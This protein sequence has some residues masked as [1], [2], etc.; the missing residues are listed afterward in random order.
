MPHEGT[1]REVVDLVLAFARR[2]GQVPI[3]LR[4]EHHGYVFNAMFSAVNREAITMAEQ[5]VASIE[6]IDR[7]WMHV[8]KSPYGPFGALDAVGLDTAWQITDYWSRQLAS[9][10][11]LRRNASFLEVYVNRGEVGVKSG[12][13]FYRYPN[14]AF[15]RPGSSRACRADAVRT[16]STPRRDSVAQAERDRRES[17]PRS[18]DG[19]FQARGG[20][21]RRTGLQRRRVG[22]VERA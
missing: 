2:I 21:G 10:P 19:V 18:G 9:D 4:H 7:A 22:P 16:C 12:Q 20:R 13:G 15:A 6:D 1:A 17:H 3:E 14:P 11:Q 8:T 5:G